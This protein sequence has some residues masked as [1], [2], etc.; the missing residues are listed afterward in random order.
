MR[1]DAQIPEK[2]DGV[3]VTE[4]DVESNAYEKGLRVG[5]VIQE[6]NDKPIKDIDDLKK[7]VATNNKTKH[8]LVVYSRNSTRFVFV[9]K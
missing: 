5:D 6:C 7:A 1:K 2:V 3:L 9:D 8:K 4:V